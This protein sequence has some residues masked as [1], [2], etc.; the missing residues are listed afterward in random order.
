MG[1]KRPEIPPI[2]DLREMTAITVEMMTRAIRAF[3]E[4]DLDTAR[5][6]PAE[7][8]SVDALFNKINAGLVE[9]MMNHKDR[10]SFA[11][12]L[13]WATHNIERMADR[14]VNICERVIFV[15]TGEMNELEESDDQWVIDL[16]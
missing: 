7:D 15:G 4:G 5:K 13:Q 14:V 11:S 12:Q 3:V 16:Q 2:H 1:E 6:L 10:I 9:D 8:D